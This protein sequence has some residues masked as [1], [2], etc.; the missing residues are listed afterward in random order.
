MTLE[1]WSQFT[2]DPRQPGVAGLRASD[3]DR[4]ALAELLAGAYSDGR[5]DSDEYQER[6]ARGMQVKRIGEIQPLVADLVLAPAP[7]PLPDQSPAKPPAK[8][9]AVL[10]D[11]SL[12]SWIGLAIMFNLIWLMAGAGYYWP[13]WPM[14]GTG[15]PVAMALFLTPR[16]KRS[17]GA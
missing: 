9:W 15:I 10:R 6:L 5:L 1:P 13:M 14:L 17:G 12:R 16:D 3:A 8:G 7:A 4:D 2:A 11:V